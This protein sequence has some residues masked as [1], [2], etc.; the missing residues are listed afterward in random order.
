M[1]DVFIYVVEYKSDKM[2][3]CNGR[4]GAS[5][6]VARPKVCANLEVLRPSERQCKPRLRQARAL[7]KSLFRQNT[8]ATRLVEGVNLQI[9]DF[10]S[11]LAQS[12]WDV[13]CYV[14]DSNVKTEKIVELNKKSKW[15]T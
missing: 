4:F 15:K 13:M 3:A 2:P 9:S 1:N 5:G 11:A 10:F 6:A 8:I 12:R 14:G 7:K